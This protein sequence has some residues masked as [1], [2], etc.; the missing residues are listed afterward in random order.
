[1]QNKKKNIVLQNVLSILI[2]MIATYAGFNG[3]KCI[4]LHTHKAKAQSEDTK[5]FAVANT[6]YL[7]RSHLN[8]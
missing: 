3:I 6:V 8:H 5:H 4:M 7:S 1:M 2:K